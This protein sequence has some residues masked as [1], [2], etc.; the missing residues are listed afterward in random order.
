MKYLED[1]DMPY[2]PGREPNEHT[3]IDMENFQNNQ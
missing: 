1:W 3:F 2:G